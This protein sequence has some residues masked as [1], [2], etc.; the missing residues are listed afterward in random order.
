[1]QLRILYS[2]ENL[3]ELFQY[4]IKTIKNLTRLGIIPS[5]DGYRPVRYDARA[6]TEWMESGKLEQH[7]PHIYHHTKGVY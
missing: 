7:R 3:V 4:D 6:I 2:A 5:L 1:M